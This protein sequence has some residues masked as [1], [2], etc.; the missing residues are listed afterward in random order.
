MAYLNCPF[1]PSQAR[2]KHP[3]LIQTLPNV[4]GAPAVEFQCIS[5]H[6]FFVTK[7][8]VDGNTREVT[9]GSGTGTVESA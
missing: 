4:K 7:E 5:K 6:K 1:C 3:A 8:S 2:P 9:E